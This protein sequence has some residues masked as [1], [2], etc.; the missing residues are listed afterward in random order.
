VTGCYGKDDVALDWDVDERAV[1]PR[2]GAMERAGQQ[3]LADAGLAK[4][5][6]GRKPARAAGVQTQETPDG[7][8]DREDARALADDLR[9]RLH[10]RTA[11]LCPPPQ[12]H[13]L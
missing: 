12:S 9:E 7:L 4:D 10:R 3:P 1:A 5:E 2:A 6:D 11:L 8:P 13:S